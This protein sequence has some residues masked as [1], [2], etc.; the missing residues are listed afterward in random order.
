LALNSIE[1]RLLQ[2]FRTVF[3]KLSEVQ[4]RNA[5]TDTIAEWDSLATAK[6]FSLV[7]EDFGVMLDIDQLD[8]MTSFIAFADLLKQQP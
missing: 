4:I 5:S 7:E 6:L 1:P 8:E 2:C 3:P